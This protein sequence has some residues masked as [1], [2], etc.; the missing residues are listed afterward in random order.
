M[1]IIDRIPKLPGVYIVMNN[2]NNKFYIG[3]S[4]NLYKRYY[5]HKLGTR[6]S[7]MKSVRILYNAYNKYNISDFTF[8]V[9]K[10][11]SDYLLWEEL[12]IKLLKPEYNIVT[13]I[14]GKSRPNLGK[15]F[16]QSW[17]NK[18]PKCK[19]HSDT[20]KALLTKLNKSNSCKLEFICNSSFEK[21]T[22][23]SWVDASK[24][25]N[26]SGISRRKIDS[27]NYSWKNYTIHKLNT[28]TKKVELELDNNIIKYFSS[29]YDCDKYLSIW[30]GAT[31]NAI[32]NNYGILHNYKVSYI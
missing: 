19:N 9:L 29:S 22:F 2:I 1:Q 23:N 16:N 24:Y 13:I 30:R 21:L 7:G 4:N 28:Q 14:N 20:T 18:L 26:V 11:T 5:S 15:K 6:A 8:Q 31:S 32:V 17:I 25:F 27:N 10:V 12:L 3:S